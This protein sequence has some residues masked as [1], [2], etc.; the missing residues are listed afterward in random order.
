MSDLK[1]FY[2]MFKIVF[3]KFTAIYFLIG[4]FG[5]LFTKVVPYGVVSVLCAVVGYL[6]LNVKVG[7]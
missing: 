6:L 5:M 1:M 7:D 2:K 4:S 3:F